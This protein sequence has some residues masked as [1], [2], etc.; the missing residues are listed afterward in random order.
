MGEILGN[1]VLWLVLLGLSFAGLDRY[2]QK[3]QPNKLI[4][5]VQHV[6]A[7]GIVLCFM[8]LFTVL[9]YDPVLIM[10]DINANGFMDM[11]G[12][13]T[14]GVLLSSLCLLTLGLFAKIR[15]LLGV[16]YKTLRAMLLSIV[17]FILLL[18]LAVCMWSGLA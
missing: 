10:F 16:Y 13:F 11:S 14:A 1:Y 18:I 2:Q 9:L 4:R 8:L 6:L 7:M 12:P 3:R 15:V 5:F 17:L